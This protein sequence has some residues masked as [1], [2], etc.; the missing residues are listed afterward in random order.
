MLLASYSLRFLPAD[1]RAAARS[2]Q[3]AASRRACSSCSATSGGGGDANVDPTVRIAYEHLLPIAEMHVRDVTGFEGASARL[4]LVTPA[5]WA[6]RTLEDYRPLF[7]QLAVS[8]ARPP[9]PD[10]DLIVNPRRI[11]ID[12]LVR[13]FLFNAVALARLIRA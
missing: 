3:C 12:N 7:T 6:Q 10:P 5:V 11:E 9:A 13:P 1:S 2:Q 4:E 8:L